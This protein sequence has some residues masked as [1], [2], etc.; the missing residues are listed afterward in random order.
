[1]LL[2]VIYRFWP[3]DD[4]VSH[5]DKPLRTVLITLA[6]DAL[7]RK[8]SRLLHK[9]HVP[10]PSSSLSWGKLRPDLSDGPRV[11]DEEQGLWSQTLTEANPGSNAVSPCASFLTSLILGFFI[12]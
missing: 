6:P 1:M 3:P 10:H 8:W 12:C 5:Q 2:V 11:N 9:T 4:L 7:I